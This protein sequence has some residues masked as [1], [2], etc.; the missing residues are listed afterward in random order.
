MFTLATFYKSPEWLNLLQQLKLARVGADGVLYCAHCGKPLIK[1]YDII[2]HHKVELTETNVNDYSVSL[3]PDNIDLIHF[4]CHNQIHERFGYE[5]PKQV[6]IVYGPP[7]S[8]KSTWVR[9]VAGPEDI[10]LDL[11]SIW[12]AITINDRYV[13]PGRLRMNVF[14]VRDCILEQVKMRV[15]KWRNAWV[16]GGYPLR[17]DRERLAQSLGAELIYIS[18]DMATCLA[19]A[20][21]RPGWDEYVRD[22]FDSYQ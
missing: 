16:I 3:N 8:G 14:G 9:S 4:R 12:Q 21:D 2:G 11:D 18:E 5:K 13:K 10:V 17:M 22:W 19:R 7:C 15:G 20:V 6:Y 1:P